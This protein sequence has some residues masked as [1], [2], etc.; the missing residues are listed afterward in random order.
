MNIP[1][2]LLSKV[3]RKPTKEINHITILPSYKSAVCRKKK[4]K[5]PNSLKIKEELSEGM[6]VKFQLTIHSSPCT[7]DKLLSN[8]QK[9]RGVLN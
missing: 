6:I 2:C 9:R 1:K 5:D 7:N 3:M 4:G 8:G